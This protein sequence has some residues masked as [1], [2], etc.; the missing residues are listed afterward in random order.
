MNCF[1]NFY[2]YNH[3]NVK[4]YKVF[5]VNCFRNFYLYNR[6]AHA[7]SWATRYTSASSTWRRAGTARGRN[8]IV[9]VR[10]FEVGCGTQ[11]E[12]AGAWHNDQRDQGYYWITQK[13]YWIWEKVNLKRILT[14]SS[15]RESYQVLYGDWFS[16][17]SVELSWSLSFSRC[18]T[19]QYMVKDSFGCPFFCLWSRPSFVKKLWIAFEIYIFDRLI[20]TLQEW[21]L[22]SR[23]LWIAFEIYIFDRLITTTIH[24]KRRYLML[25][26]AF[27]IYIF[28]R[29]ITTA[30]FCAIWRLSLWIAFEIYIFD[31][32]I[33]TE[34]EPFLLLASCEL[35]SKFI[36]L[37]DW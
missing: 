6:T 34:P 15:Q 5:V 30:E 24:G 36:S 26:I 27:E 18:N 4:S 31:R 21:W 33:T 32:L 8:G 35:L 14:S 9:C 17:S 16:A 28:D 37:T 13:Q 29:L 11:T 7:L 3:F 22:R 20:T 12:Q 19:S 23:L 2:L 10:I 25:W 1:R